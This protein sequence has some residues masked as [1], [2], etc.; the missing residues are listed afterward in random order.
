[1]WV[2]SSFVIPRRRRPAG[3]IT[4]SAGAGVDGLVVVDLSAEE[5]EQLCL[6]ALKGRLRF[7]RA[8]HATKDDLRD[9][10]P[11]RGRPILL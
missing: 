9:P 1:M 10:G 6:P 5:D 4:G 8:R 3:P 7:Y 2:S 11:P